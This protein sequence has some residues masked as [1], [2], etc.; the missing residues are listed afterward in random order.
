MNT[1]KTKLVVAFA[2]GDKPF[3]ETLV[4]DL[5]NTGYNVSWQGN[6]PLGVDWK[7][8]MQSE[9]DAASAVLVCF[10]TKTAKLDATGVYQEVRFAIERYAMHGP[11]TPYLIPVRFD[12][13][14]VPPFPVDGSRTLRHL[15]FLDFF[16]ANQQSKAIERLVQTLPVEKPQ[17]VSSADGPS[18]RIGEDKEEAQPAAQATQIAH[19]HQHSIFSLTSSLGRLG[20]A[21][22][23]APD[24]A[25]TALDLVSDGETV[26]NDVTLSMGS[27]TT[28]ATVTQRLDNE[29]IALLHTVAVEGVV[30][31]RLDHSGRWEGKAAS[32]ISHQTALF[33]ASVEGEKLQIGLSAARDGVVGAAVI[34]EKNE[35]SAIVTTPPADGQSEARI[36][37]VSDWAP[38]LDLGRSVPWLTLLRSEA[39]KRG[40]ILK[41][42]QDLIAQLQASQHKS[43]EWNS[44]QGT[45][46]LKTRLD[47]AD[48]VR[49]LCRCQVAVCDGGNFEPVMMLLLGIR[50]VVRRGVTI[51]SVPGQHEDEPIDAPFNI[52]DANFVVHGADDSRREPWER[53]LGPVETAL[54]QISSPAYADLPAYTGVRE[55]PPGERSKVSILDGILLLGSF[56]S[57]YHRN[58]RFVAGRCKAAQSV[59]RRVEGVEGPAKYGIARSLELDSPRLVSHAIYAALRRWEFCVVDWTDWRPNVF[60][61]LGVRLAA[62]DSPTLNIIDQESEAAVRRIAAARESE[63]V[64]EAMGHAE[65]RGLPEADRTAF[66]RRLVSIAPQCTALL[67]LFEH[68]RYSVDPPVDATARDEA[69]PLNDHLVALARNPVRRCGAQILVRRLA[70]DWASTSDEPA[71]VPLYRD[72]LRS[73][74]LLDADETEGM[75]AML[76]PRNAGLRTAAEKARRERAF[77]AWNALS[78]VT[79]DLKKTIELDASLLSQCAQLVRLLNVYRTT[80]FSDEIDFWAP[81]DDFDDFLQEVAAEHRRRRA[82]RKR[83]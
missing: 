64:N 55:L 28:T 19:V 63:R 81:I 34:D 39:D 82:E 58:Y 41:Q 10:S 18:V 24:F 50:A 68:T 54:E 36:S 45:D 8:W 16:P 17:A 75:S 60:F 13:C 20:S 37:H 76:F 61:E 46:A 14:D 1:I 51:V 79:D 80:I 23:V 35:F 6:M 73:V 52:K 57:N 48:A 21:I 47:F 27:S 29:R 72:L 32:V 11:L 83:R 5:E 9:M 25:V 30:P 44:L 22:A 77:A 33:N 31:M 56:Q 53:M 4:R 62:T 26:V 49:N 43:I 71:T 12:D 2:G 38:L 67:D 74:Q 15:L 78:P 69:T 7:L 66:S 40:D 42:T 3:V 59:L 65:R 70:E